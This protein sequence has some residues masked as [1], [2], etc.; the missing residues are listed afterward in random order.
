MYHHVLIESACLLIG[1]WC[2]YLYVCITNNATQ[3]IIEKD[4]QTTSDNQILFL[5]YMGL[6]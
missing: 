6:I 1:I 4:K 2:I 3:T 5:F